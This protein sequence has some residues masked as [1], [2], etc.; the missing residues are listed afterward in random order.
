MNAWIDRLRVRTRFLALGLVALLLCAVPTALHLRGTWA[1]MHATEREVDGIEPAKALLKVVQLTQQ[2]RGLSA[3]FLGNQAG[4]DATRTAKQ[5]EVDKALETAV[6]ALQALPRGSAASAR[7]AANAKD[8]QAL[9]ERVAARTATVPESFAGHTALLAQLLQTL[10][11]S[12]DDSGLSLDSEMSTYKLMQATNFT[13]PALMEEPA[14]LAPRAA[15]CSPRATPR[16]ST[17]RRSAR[18]RPRRRPNS[19]A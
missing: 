3:L 7:L 8:W 1:T 17:S 4:A 14:R 19:S 5:A 10:E 6:T 9:R 16:R 12:A 13:L 2:H 15:A 11:Q 18:S